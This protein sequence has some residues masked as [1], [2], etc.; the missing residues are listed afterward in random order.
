M[1]FWN[2]AIFLH[3]FAFFGDVYYN[4]SV[5]CELQVT[6]LTAVTAQLVRIAL[7]ERKG[8]FMSKNGVKSTPKMA[9][10]ASKVLQGSQSKATKSLAASVLSNAKKKTK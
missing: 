3:N 4:R 5:A 8:D 9:S 2:Y 10:K 7:F 6:I 1:I